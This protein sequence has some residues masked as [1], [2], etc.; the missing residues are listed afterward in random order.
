MQADSAA[1]HT[2]PQS[3]YESGAIPNDLPVTSVS[4]PEKAPE[5]SVP[6]DPKETATFSR[7]KPALTHLRDLRRS[8]KDVL[9]AIWLPPEGLRSRGAQAIPQ[10][11]SATY[12]QDQSL[13]RDKNPAGLVPNP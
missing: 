7:K 2:A 9:A 12:D 8:D 3:G 4:I 11:R 5:Q 6:K 1:A 13:P 10:K